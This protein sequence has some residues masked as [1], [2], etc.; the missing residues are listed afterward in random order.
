MN[1]SRLIKAMAVIGLVGFGS[2]A[3]ASWTTTASEDFEEPLVEGAFEPQSPTGWTVDPADESEI[4]SAGVSEFDSET[5]A[6]IESSEVVSQV[7]QLDTQGNELVFEAGTEQYA[8]VRVEMLVQMVGSED[9]DP[10]LSESDVRT[11]VYLNTEDPENPVLKGLTADGWIEFPDAG[12]VENEWIKLQIEIEYETG[13]ELMEPRV[14][15]IVNGV[16]LADASEATSF[17]V[18]N[19]EASFSQ[20]NVA[21]VVFQGTGL[22]EDL[23]V[24]EQAFSIPTATVIREAYDAD[25]LLETQST[26]LLALTGTYNWNFTVDIG[27]HVLDRVELIAADGTTVL[28]TL[29]PDE[30]TE[31][32]QIGAFD[33]ET[34]IAGGLLEDETYYVRGTYDINVYEVFVEYVSN[35]AGYTPANYSDVVNHGQDFVINVAALLVS[36]DGFA[37]ENDRD[38][39]LIE[40]PAADPSAVTVAAVTQDGITL[41]LYGEWLDPM[42]PTDPIDFDPVDAELVFDDLDLATGVVSFTAKGT[43]NV[44]ESFALYLI[45]TEDLVNGPDFTIEVEVLAEDVDGDITGTATIELAELAGYDTLF[46][47]GLS[48][49][50]PA[51]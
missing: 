51:L 6:P 39:E 13:F 23:F 24:Q 12:V 32:I 43:V 37:Y 50:A 3:L 25:G 16:L 21:E 44:A 28:A 35:T 8:A 17:V 41:T 27:S 42:G 7:L 36:T 19:T 33:A 49:T 46:I 10:D 1:F 29:T 26:Q 4:I 40:D 45:V 2:Q 11:A 31:G 30:T 34:V 9:G 14:S 15:Y 38:A 20:G 22:V 18:A 47:K 48:T 5:G